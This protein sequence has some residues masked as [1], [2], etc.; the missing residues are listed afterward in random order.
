MTTVA[1]L[2]KIMGW[3]DE[4]AGLVKESEKHESK[5]KSG[6]SGLFGKKEEDTPEEEKPE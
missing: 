1:D 3:T 2:K 6:K 5:K 4:Q